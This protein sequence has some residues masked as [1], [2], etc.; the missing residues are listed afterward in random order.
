MGKNK[1]MTSKIIIENYPHQRG[2]HCE[3]GSIKNMLKFYGHDIS[4]TMIFGIGSGFDF[5]HFPFRF[6]NGNEIPIF[7]SIF[8]QVFRKFSKRMGIDGH[9][10]FFIN[11]KRSMKAIDAL[12]KQNIPVGLVSEVS[13]LPFFPLR[14]RQFSG[15][16]FV[17]FGKDSNEYIVGDTD[18]HFPDDSAQRISYE[19]LM[20]ARFTKDLLSPRGAMFYIKSTPDHFDIKKGILEGI[21][22]TCHQ[23][24]GIPLPYFGVKGIYYLSNRIKNYT[25]IYGEK[26]AWRNIRFQIFI[27]EEGGSGG[28]GFRYLYAN[29]LKEAAEYLNDHE[30]M[31]ISLSMR[32]IADQWQQFA[33]EANRQCEE[34]KEKNI[35]YLANMIHCC[36]Q[37]EEKLFKELKK[38]TITKLK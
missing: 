25:K 12:L 37:M 10:S 32:E 3:T 26:Q 31:T 8:V 16:H 33:L 5:M 36:A 2:I 21:K 17:V 34:R 14:D 15:H 11:K 6:F 20:N 7:R 38:W 30:L 4:E 28:S 1:L 35:V 23:M 19:D 18:P 9:I 29:F 27:S 13:R 24:L 22:N